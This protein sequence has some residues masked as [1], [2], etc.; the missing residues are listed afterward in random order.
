MFQNTI[1]MRQL[2]ILFTVPSLSLIGG[3]A[4][5]YSGLKNYWTENVKYN[6]IGKR[7]NIKGIYWLPFDIIK[8]TLSLIFF[9][10]DIVILNPSLGVS[11]LK[12]DTIFLTLS[13]LLHRKTALFFHGF[14]E[15][16]VTNIDKKRLT[17]TLNRNVCI[18]VLAKNFKKTFEMWGVKVPIYTMT[19]KVDDRLVDNFNI[20]SRTGNIQNLLFL[21]RITIE[22]GIFIAIQAYQKLQNLHPQLKLTI[23]GKGDALKEAE[24]YCAKN[25]L[26]HVIFTGALQGEKLKEAFRN[27]DLYLFPSFHE[28]MPTS[29]LEAMAFGIPVITRPVGGLVDFF[30]NGKMGKMVDSMKPSDFTDA[31]EPLLTNANLVKQMSQYNYQYAQK[32]FLASRIALNMENKLKTVLNFKG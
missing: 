19:T 4:N 30:E 3:V 25:N 18:F 31:I 5:H 17:K 21:S 29:V 8:F 6:I 26:Q 13:R 16:A 10:P 15:N 28:G 27:G 7:H 9:S 22:K 32:H 11:A 2:K 12:R 14:N 24:N 20:H 23:V 1:K